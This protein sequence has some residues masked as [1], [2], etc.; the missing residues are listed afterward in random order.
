[1]LEKG[2]KDGDKRLVG[3]PPWGKWW[4]KCL[5]EVR[6]ELPGARANPQMCTYREL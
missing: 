5:L 1:V 3:E 4:G 2:T 6:G